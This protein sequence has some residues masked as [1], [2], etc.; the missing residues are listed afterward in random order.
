MGS[1]TEDEPWQEHAGLM[2]RVALRA[3]YRFRDYV[4]LDDLRQEAWVTYFGNRA[5]Y[6]RMIAESDY[7]ARVARANISRHVLDY[8]L[9]EKAQRIGYEVE[10]QYWYSRQEL[11]AIL[12]VVFVGG[13]TPGSVEVGKT[14]RSGASTYM[15]METSC[16]DVKRALLHL[17]PTD[18]QYLYDAWGPHGEEFT[19]NKA[20]MIRAGQALGRLQRELG[21]RPPARINYRA[22]AERMTAGS[23]SLVD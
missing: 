6:D 9:Q 7:W 8:A 19:T 14:R 4:T 21:E 15:D 12:G 2:E 13:V 23:F 1:V 22:A 18:R 5:E 20:M 3:Y 10:D 16:A 11:K 17:S